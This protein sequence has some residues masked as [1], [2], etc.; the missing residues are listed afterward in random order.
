MSIDLF[1]FHRD[2]HENNVLVTKQLT[3]ADPKKAEFYKPKISDL[4]ESTLSTVPTSGRIYGDQDSWAPEVR[5]LQ[6]YSTASDVYSIGWIFAKMVKLKW[7]RTAALTGEKNCQAPK[8]M[9]D[10]IRW[11]TK[12]EP[13]ERPESDELLGEFEAVYVESEEDM[14]NN[15]VF[16]MVELDPDTI[17]HPARIEEE[18]PS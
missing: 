4:S 12:P 1:C 6:K 10:I 13:E 7:D 5:L 14:D 16:E 17:L 8:R 9:I 18:I 11:C 3:P 15:M 2:L